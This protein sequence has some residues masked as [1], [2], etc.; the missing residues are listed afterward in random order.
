MKRTF[1]LLLVW[2]FCTTGGTLLTGCK[3]QAAGPVCPPCEQA[4]ERSDYFELQRLL[5]QTPGLP[6]AERNYYQAAVDLAFNRLEPAATSLDRLLNS[7]ELVHSRRRAQVAL[8]VQMVRYR[9]GRYAEA[10]ALADLLLTQQRAALTPP[11]IASLTNE[12]KVVEALREQLPQRVT[13][14]ADTRV[15][16][17]RD[18]LGLWYLPVEVAGTQNELLFDTGAGFSVLTRSKAVEMGLQPLGAAF[19][20]GTA[21]SI[22]VLADL[23]VA[24]RLRIGQ[25][26]LENVVFL[27]Y[28]DEVLTFQLPTGPYRIEGILGYNVMQALGKLTLHNDPTGSGLTLA[29]TAP[30]SLASL[31]GEPANFF[32]DGFSP[33]VRVTYGSDTL[34]MTFDSGGR[35]S[36][37]WFPFYQRYGAELEKRPDVSRRPT[38]TGGVGGA[39]TIEVLRVP[40]PTF[41][42]AGK[43]VQLPHI[44]VN[45]HP[46]GAAHPY[47]DGNLG[48]DIMQQYTHLSVDFRRMRISGE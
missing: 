1:F 34:L 8:L 7:P 31:A 17:T 37:L 33:V 44:N 19:E 45:L 14:F 4:V 47:R 20:V 6:A 2:V 43:S 9:Q 29:I 22:R 16:M 15:N 12:R 21:T 41:T 13:T 11:E 38:R 35:A 28:P 30:D 24:P 23:A 18:S 25:V 48:L 36:D 42:M 39:Q 26:E 3:N 46:Y 40:D 32:M 5:P 10:F 27:V